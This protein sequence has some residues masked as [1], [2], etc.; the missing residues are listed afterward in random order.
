MMIP[1]LLGKSDGSR[2]NGDPL[3]WKHWR[4]GAIDGPIPASMTETKGSIG[5]HKM[6]ENDEESQQN[7]EKNVF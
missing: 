1:I 2:G 7:G 4:T 6:L 5:R 3:A